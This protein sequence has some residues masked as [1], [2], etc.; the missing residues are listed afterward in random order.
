MGFTLV[1]EW[2]G[3]KCVVVGDHVVVVGKVVDVV[4]GDGGGEDGL[5]YCGGKYRGVGGEVDLEGD[6]VGE[7]REDE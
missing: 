6:G 3:E 5:V 4:G 2:V 7:G 1:C